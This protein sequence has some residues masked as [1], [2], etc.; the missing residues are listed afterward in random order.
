MLC[1][2]DEGDDDDD[3]ED[4]RVKLSASTATTS[5]FLKPDP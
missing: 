1:V 5:P 2:G 4:D 3:E